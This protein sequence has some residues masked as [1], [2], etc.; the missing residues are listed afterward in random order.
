MIRVGTCTFRVVPSLCQ[1]LCSIIGLR[2]RHPL[3]PGLAYFLAVTAKRDAIRAPGLFSDLAVLYSVTSSKNLIGAPS[4]PC[5][6]HILH[7][8]PSGFT[9]IGVDGAIYSI[10]KLIANEEETMTSLFS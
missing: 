3:S 10:E 5:G 7:H 1:G 8:K 9:V 4:V 2:R 6:I